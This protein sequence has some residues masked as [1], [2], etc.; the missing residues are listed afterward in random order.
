MIPIRK[1]TQPTALTDALRELRMTPNASVSWGEV[2][3]QRPI[4]E[5]L[6]REQGGLC[7]YCMKKI[8]ADTS[9]VEHIVPQSAC[10]PGEDVAYGNMLAVCDGNEGAGYAGALTCDRA[11]QDRAL[12]VNPLK[13]ETLK[14]IGYRRNGEITSTDGAVRRDLCETLNLNCGAAYLPQNR[15]AVIDALNRWMA[16]QRGNVAGECRRRREAIEDSD[17]KPEFAGVLL[18]FLDRRIRRG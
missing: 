12:T 7:A 11:R 18:Y 4:R 14:G 8:T 3:N 1:G 10:K 17:V 9:H 5:A 13:P 2:R 15:K 6:C 16:A